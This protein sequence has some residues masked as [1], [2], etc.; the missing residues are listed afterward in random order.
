MT[1]CQN[2]TATAARYNFCSGKR[3]FNTRPRPGFYK[4]SINCY[5]SVNE[6][7]DAMNHRH[8][9]AKGKGM[10]HAFSTSVQS[11]HAPWDATCK[12]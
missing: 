12:Q 9:C 6:I 7:V 2:T 4:H 5:H 8:F 10:L 1:S 11:M 3:P